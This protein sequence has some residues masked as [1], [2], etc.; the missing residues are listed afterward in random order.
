MRSIAASYQL[1][2]NQPFAAGQRGFAQAVGGLGLS[3]SE[4]AALLAAA[5]L[6][7]ARRPLR[8]DDMAMAPIRASLDRMLIKHE[9]WPSYVFAADGTV[10]QRNAGIDD[11]LDWLSPGACLWR[12]TGP[13]GRLNIFDLSLHPSGVVQWLSKPALTVP[14]ILRRLRRAARDDAGARRT[15]ARVCRYPAA[16]SAGIGED[17]AAGDPDAVVAESYEARGLPLRF[18][19]TLSHFGAAEDLTAESVTIETLIPADAE[20]AEALESIARSPDRGENARQARRPDGRLFS[21]PGKVRR[22]SRE[23]G[24]PIPESRH[25]LPRGVR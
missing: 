5:G 8:W 18:L 2:R 17:D 16:A 20:T 7:V 19:A 1:S 21:S 15:L 10:L 13:D 4:A 24:N 6:R 11:L 14:H 3:G 23:G 25:A 9:P 12:L 22:Y